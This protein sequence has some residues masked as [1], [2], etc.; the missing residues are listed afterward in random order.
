[1]YSLPIDV[2]NTFETRNIV[3]DAKKALEDE[4]LDDALITAMEFEL[5]WMQRKHEFYDRIANA[6][7]SRIEMIT[8]RVEAAKNAS[9]S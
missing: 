9:L 1:M 8:K 4:K 5:A 3:F 7:I 6:E 2:F